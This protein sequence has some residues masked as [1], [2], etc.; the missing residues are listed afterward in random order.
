MRL[1]LT[2]ALALLTTPAMACGPDT[3]CSVLGDRTYRYYMPDGTDGP[4][5]A[6]FHAHGYRGSAGGAM[7]NQSLRAMADRLGMAFVALNADADD[8]NLAYRPRNPTQTEAAEDDYARAVIADLATRIDLDPSR[9]ISTGFSAGGMMTWTLA[10]EMG[11]T[12]AGFVPYAGTFWRTIPDAC[13]TPASHLIHI[14]GDADRTVP[15]EGR[16]IGPTRQGD[17]FE[18][19]AMYGDH[20][21]FSIPV[22]LAAPDGMLC[23]GGEAALGRELIFCTFEG[24]HSYS[25]ARVEWAIE[26]ILSQL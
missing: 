13:P 26:R 25:T 6:F 4:V 1:A 5:G 9:L 15:L 19:L 2:A 8:W 24:G 17:V 12:F 14:H 11:D 18:A 23:V 3:D 20:G 21:G 16:A 22:P 10:C 7:R